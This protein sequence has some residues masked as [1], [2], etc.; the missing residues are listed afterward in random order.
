MDAQTIEITIKAHLHEMRDRL[1]KAATPFSRCT[2]GT[3]RI[4]SNSPGSTSSATI[5]S[6]PRLTVSTIQPTMSA[7]SS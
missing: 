1:E 6:I 3:S 7:I 5:F 4:R 2:S